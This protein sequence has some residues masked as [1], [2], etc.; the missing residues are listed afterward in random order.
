[1][2][3]LIIN[4]SPRRA[5]TWQLIERVKDDLNDLDEN[6]EFNEI[7]L[8]NENIPFCTGC[9]SCFNNGEETCPHA[10]IVQPIV[11]K[12]INADGIIISCPVYALNTTALLK[13]FIDH[14]AYFYHRPY[15]FEKKALIVVT[16]AGTGHKKVGNYID[17]TLRNMGYNKRF[18]LCFVTAHDKSGYL[19]LKTKQKIDAETNK[20]Y[21]SIKSNKLDSPSLKAMFYYNV[22]R[23][24]ATNA[25]IKKDHEYWVENDL[26]NYE[27]YPKI[28]YNIV[29]K[30]IF[31]IFYKILLTMMSKNTIEEEN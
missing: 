29:K 1:M 6:I 5:N 26:I 3:F 31:K 19:P 21:E 11:D 17:E 22:W 4:S 7:D 27:F 24:M 8:I 30:V 23:V 12:M 14:L 9:Y 20:F 10:S 15:F 18:K 16:T 25:Y 13:N 28:N 2:N